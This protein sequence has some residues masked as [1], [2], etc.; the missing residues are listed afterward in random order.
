MSLIFCK[1]NLSLIYGITSLALMLSLLLKHGLNFSVGFFTRWVCELTHKM[2]ASWQIWRGT[3]LKPILWTPPSKGSKVLMCFESCINVVWSLFSNCLFTIQSIIFLWS[4]DL[5]FHNL[6][7]LFAQGYGIADYILKFV[8]RYRLTIS[9]IQ[10][11][12]FLQ[13][14]MTFLYIYLKYQMFYPL[15]S[16]CYFYLCRTL[17][18][19]KGGNLAPTRPKLRLRV[20]IWP[21]MAQTQTSPADY[22]GFRPNINKIIDLGHQLWARLKNGRGHL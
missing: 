10:L 5:K 7:A 17:I 6:T 18:E 22:S 15:R 11:H 9:S 4:M 20:G 3:G 1:R 2:R 13:E 14:N 21:G 16:M 12:P 19:T 8:A